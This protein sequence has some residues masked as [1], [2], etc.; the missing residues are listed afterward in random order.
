MHPLGFVSPFLRRVAFCRGWRPAFTHRSFYP[1]LVPSTNLNLVIGLTLVN[2]RGA[3][4]SKS[5]A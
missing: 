2:D 5:A 3:A 1:L 4:V